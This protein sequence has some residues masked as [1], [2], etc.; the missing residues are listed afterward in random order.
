M[1]D[2][3]PVW[4]DSVVVPCL[5]LVVSRLDGSAVRK[6]RTKLYVF[7]SSQVL[8]APA[9]LYTLALSF[10]KQ[11]GGGKRS[12]ASCLLCCLFV[13]LL[14]LHSSF[15]CM[16]EDVLPLCMP[17]CL[18]CPFFHHFCSLHASYVQ[19]H[20]SLLP[21]CSRCSYPYLK[22]CLADSMTKHVLL[23]HHFS[24][25]VFRFKAS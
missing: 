21:G 16:W 14:S 12:C 20:R 7:F 25:P 2:S 23:L 24:P 11:W 9:S 18:T 4:P 10:Q 1:P 3:E 17:A 15:F 19:H 6:V 8:L 13:F 5:E 22:L